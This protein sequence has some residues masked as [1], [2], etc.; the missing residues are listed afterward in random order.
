MKTFS[1]YAL[2][3]LSAAS[4]LQ[5]QAYSAYN[6]HSIYG[7]QWGT[8]GS[9]FVDTSDWDGENNL[10]WQAV[11]ECFPDKRYDW[12]ASSPYDTDAN[13]YDNWACNLA[14]DNNWK[15]G[16]MFPCGADEST[17]VWYFLNDVAGTPLGPDG[18]GKIGCYLSDESYGQQR[19]IQFPEGYFILNKQ[20]WMPPL[21]AITGH[22][23]PNGNPYDETYFIA[24]VDGDKD[25]YDAFGSSLTN[26]D[27]LVNPN[28]GWGEGYCN[29]TGDFDY[30]SWGKD[31]DGNDDDAFTHVKAYRK[32]FSMHGSTY[33]ANVNILGSD[34]VQCDRKKT[35][36][37]AAEV[38]SK[39]PDVLVRT[40]PMKT[41]NGRVTVLI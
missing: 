6:A 1:I 19:N 11:V 16:S 40:G 39:L 36:L 21:T 13:N 24:M 30:F 34:T 32:G 25:G 33:L 37:C 29:P 3:C 12:S 4:R 38:P 8:D 31:T 28:D 10:S 17:P 15:D 35:E 7:Y 18:T 41:V 5:V 23:D 14:F 20:V 9:T 26:A 27:S 22:G 2:A